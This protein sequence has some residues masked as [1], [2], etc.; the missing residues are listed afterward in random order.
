MSALAPA[1][2][3]VKPVGTCFQ[4]GD[5]LS[6]ASHVTAH[7]DGK[8]ERMCCVGCAAVARAIF[9]AGLGAYYEMR[10]ANEKPALDRAAYAAL[11]AT[12]DAASLDIADVRRSY[13]E[14]VDRDH[15]RLSF[16]LDGITCP[17]CL[18]LAESTLR[19]LPG[20]ARVDVNYHT[21]Q[22]DVTSRT[23]QLPPSAIVHAI[24]RVGL[25]ATPV[26]GGDA[27]GTIMRTERDAL[28]RLGVAFFCMMQIMMLAVPR[29]FVDIDEASATSLKLMDWT[30]LLLTIPVIFFSAEDIFRKA[31]AAL[32]GGHLGM[33][34][35]IALAI[36]AT[37]ASSAVALVTGSGEVYF[38]SI[39][40]FVC[41]LGAARYA[42]LRVRNRARKKILR[43]ANALPLTAQR[44]AAYPHTRE[45]T[46]V[47]AAALRPGDH[48]LVAEGM[49]IPVDGDIVEGCAS[50]D[51]SLLTGE[52]RPVEKREGMP[53]S[54]GTQNVASPFVMR[55]TRTLN[56]SAVAVTERLMRTA[57][58]LR[59]PT[60]VWSDS[61]ARFIAPAT[62]VLALVAGL[63]WLIVDASQAFNVV[64]AVLAVTCPCAIALAAPTAYAAATSRLIERGLLIADADWMSTL[65]AITDVVFDKTGTLTTGQMV[66]LSQ[67]VAPAVSPED[68]LNIARALEVGASH[69]VAEALR[70]ATQPER[71]PPTVT[72]WRHHPGA[73]VEGDVGGATYRFGRAAFACPRAGVPASDQAFVLSRNGAW[74]ATFRF[75]D[76][77]RD[78]AKLVVEALQRIGLGVHILSGDSIARARDVADRLGV[79][80]ANVTAEKSAAEKAQYLQ[81]L[82]NDPA[83]ARRVLMVGDGVNDGPVL[84]MANASIAVAGNRADLPKHAAGAVLVAPRLTAICDAIDVSKTVMR[85][86]RQNFAWA[87]AYN[88]IAVPLAMLNYITPA[89]AA[90]GMALSSL[91]VVVNSMRLSWVRQS[92]SEE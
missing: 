49:I 77:L 54:G 13:E 47:A 1:L 36:A 51:E 12:M 91:V 57:L 15:A 84:A 18:W 43:L 5:A 85:V 74:Q 26:A 92:A 67:D 21:H 89:W 14:P 48:V 81:S 73:G 39:A 71:E 11:D 59:P 62:L 20:V 22:A 63:A 25:R 45:T 23:E 10:D 29:Y 19:Q 17:A 72:R 30:S 46:L 4:C 68:A 40:M 44:L 34:F 52:A 41:L 56:A 64:V 32:R 9:D 28:K 78:E 7:L 70:R 38:D 8:D 80:A 33:D 69:P 75:D 76:P 79:P 16:Y 3:Q 37:F 88:V 60:A 82:M 61:V 50:V 65:P 53:V 6:A 90:V 58:G 35:P 42:E 2:L 87:V 31:W 66:L 24:A 86:V 27:L 55:V 83:H